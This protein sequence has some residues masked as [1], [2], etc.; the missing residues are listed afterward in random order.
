MEGQGKLG[1]GGGQ[2]SAGLRVLKPGE[3]HN[4]LGNVL[5]D[6]GQIAEAIASYERALQLVPSFNRAHSNLLCALHYRAGVTLSELAA[7][8]ADFDRKS[9][10][11]SNRP[12][13]R[14]GTT[15]ILNAGCG[16][17]SCRRICIATRWGI[18]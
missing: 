11:R 10:P 7:A 5:K 4:N 9:A 1:R 12:G 13:S 17:A 3:A 6:Q 16:S 8:H 18:S 2:L 15:P 14:L